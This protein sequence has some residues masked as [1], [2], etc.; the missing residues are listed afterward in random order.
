MNITEP[1]ANELK[2]GIEKFNSPGAGIRI[3]S[4][5]GCCGPSIQMEVSQKPAQDDVVLTLEDIDFFLENDLFDTL[6]P[7]TIDYGTGGFRII[8]LK[9]SGGCCG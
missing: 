8:G 9:R 6:A 5:S 3:F 4:V 7:V 2:K 1:A